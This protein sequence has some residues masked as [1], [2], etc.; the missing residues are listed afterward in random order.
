MTSFMLGR[1]SGSGLRH[2]ATRAAMEAEH[3][4]GTLQDAN[5]QL[6]KPWAATMPG[7]QALQVSVDMLRDHAGGTHTSSKSAGAGGW[8]R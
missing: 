1:S 8:G 4:L 3:S 5:E 6:K 2:A 7:M